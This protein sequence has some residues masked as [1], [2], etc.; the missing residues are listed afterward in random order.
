MIMITITITIL[1]Y[2]D[3]GKYK[4]YINEKKQVNDT[5]PAQIGPIGLYKMM[6]VY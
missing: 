3:I 4:N 6:T 1:Y 5:P 2:I